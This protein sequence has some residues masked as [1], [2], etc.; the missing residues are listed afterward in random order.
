M[1]RRN[2]EEFFKTIGLPIF[3][4]TFLIDFKTVDDKFNNAKFIEE[5]NTL[6]DLIDKVYEEN[7]FEPLYI[8]LAARWETYKSHLWNL[9]KGPTTIEEI[10]EDKKL[11]LEFC[12]QTGIKKLFDTFKKEQLK[13]Y[14]YG[15]EAGLNTNAR[16]NRSGN[17][18][19]KQIRDLLSLAKFQK[20]DDK[21][22]FKLKEKQYI[23]EVKILSKK[24]DFVLKKN[25][26]IFLV[27]SS[28]YNSSGSKPSEVSRSYRTVSIEGKKIG[29]FIWIV[30]GKGVKTIKNRIDEAWDEIKIYNVYTFWMEL[31][32]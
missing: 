13:S 1:E 14:I 5:I 22:V 28:S 29:E 30:D 23:E 9:S 7:N 18:Q 2:K 26:K 27:E 31:L 17:R 21:N 25:D 10:L 24:Y 11:I 16:K 8:F 12:M 19:I 32:K 4:A 15:V 20:N 6:E 3:E